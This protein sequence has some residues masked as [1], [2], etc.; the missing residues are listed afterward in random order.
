MIDLPQVRVA[1]NPSRLGVVL[2]GVARAVVAV[3]PTILPLE[4]AAGTLTPAPGPLAVV[5]RAAVELEGTV[6]SGVWARNQALLLHTTRPYR[7][8]AVSKSGTAETAAEY[9]NTRHLDFLPSWEVAWGFDGRLWLSDG[10]G[11]V[12][13]FDTDLREQEMLEFGARKV[14]GCDVMLALQP[15]PVD[16]DLVVFATC[17]NRRQPNGGYYGYARLHLGPEPVLSPLRALDESTEAGGLAWSVPT[18]ATSS[19]GVFALVFEAGPHIE[20]VF[21][22]PQVIRAFPEGFAEV[23]DLARRE[24]VNPPLVFYRNVEAA[25]M[26]AGLF[27]QGRYLYLLTRRPAGKGTTSWFLHRIDPE[28]DRIEATFVLP[29]DAPH[30]VVVP[31]PVEWALV[32]QDA[33]VGMLGKRTRCVLFLSASSLES[34]GNG[35]DPPRGPSGR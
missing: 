5:R 27:G 9:P 8:V 17:R 35:V 7:L 21:P 30:L 19:K 34:A 31:G 28:R 23:P 3:C 16:R 25:S 22:R 2:R 18:L 11:R 24:H 10:H 15:Q 29:T 1:G 26:A 6:Q 14:P 20:R 13:T 12:L 32:E 33:W 4:R